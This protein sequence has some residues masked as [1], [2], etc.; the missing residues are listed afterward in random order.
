MTPHGSQLSKCTND[1][2]YTFVRTD[3]AASLFID[4]IEDI[5]KKMIQKF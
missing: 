1:E 3:D 4:F 2:S 5:D